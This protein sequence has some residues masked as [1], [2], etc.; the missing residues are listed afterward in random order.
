MKNRL[1]GA[2]RSLSTPSGHPEHDPVLMGHITEDT[3]L[4]EE[5]VRERARGTFRLVLHRYTDLS[6]STIDKFVHRVISAFAKD[7]DVPEDFE[8]EVEEEELLERSVDLLMNRIGRDETLTEFILDFTEQKAADEKSWH[9]EK[10]LIAFATNLLDEASERHIEELREYGISD[11]KSAQK[12]IQQKKKEALAYLKR[13]GEEALEAIEEADLTPDRLAGGAKSGIHKYFTYLRD[14]RI[15]NLYP[16]STVQKAFNKGILAAKKADDRDRAAIDHIT[17]TLSELYQKALTYLDEHLA[18]VQLYDMLDR[19]IPGLALIGEVEKILEE[20]KAENDLLLISDLNKTI[21]RWV[22][23]E[24]APF[25][26]ERIGERYWNFLIDEFQDTSVM[27]WQN[28]L[29]LIE[30]ALSGGHRTMLVGDGKQ[31]IY[32]WRNGDVE[33]FRKLPAIHRGEEE[34]LIREKEPVLRQHYHVETLEVNRRSRKGIVEANNRFFEQLAQHLPD[35]YRETLYQDTRQKTNEKEEKGYVKIR[36]LEDTEDYATQMLTETEKVV[37]EALREGYHNGDIAILTRTNEKG[38]ELARHLTEAGIDVISSE[39][40]LLKQHPVVQFLISIFRYLRHF[41]NETA[42]LNAIAFL[43]S[44]AGRKAGHQDLAHYSSGQKQTYIDLKEYLRDQGYDQNLERLLYEPLYEAT[45]SLIQ[46]FKLNQPA[47]AFLQFFLDHV[48]GFSTKRDNEIEAFLDDWDQRSDNLSIK[49]PEGVNAVRVMT[50]H[51]AKGLEFPVVI[52]PF[53]D[54]NVRFG[55]RYIWVNTK[56]YTEGL[57]TA[58]LPVQKQLAQTPF[59][60]QYEEEQALSRIDNFNLLYVAMTRAEERL[61]VLTKARDL[62]NGNSIAEYIYNIATAESAWDEATQTLTLGYP[63]SSATERPEPLEQQP[64]VDQLP[65]HPWRGRQVI[66]QQ[67]PESWSVE[68]PEGKRAHGEKIHS[69]LARIDNRD[70]VGQAIEEARSEGLIEADETPSLQDRLERLLQG[71]PTREWFDPSL[72]IYRE[73]EIIA[74]N[75]GIYRPDRVV[76]GLQ[77]TI[78]IDF[79]TGSETASDHDQVKRYIK[80][81]K[82]AGHE[83]VKGF[84]LYVGEERAVEVNPPG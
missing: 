58:I 64:L 39:S 81:L 79:K 9:I 74:P 83:F 32:R 68:D 7:I 3:G 6:V 43:E 19:N 59:H 16:S 41:D 52:L 34:P 25:I 14:Q 40:L 36:S 84:L 55:Q 47:T 46:T 5:T 13:I 73:R 82:E 71:S 23:K 37:R 72:E 8:V 12:S 69:I 66:S 17:P 29:P 26:Y 80:L 51:S 2:L 70:E 67:A 61:F 76:R 33:Q 24:P 78:V 42:K 38:T 22:R 35:P 60:Q 77:G 31:A 27:Q 44:R 11:F 53:A 75:G 63:D 57:K 49:V 50:I 18:N 4:E 54:W 56:A 62:K 15:E 30:N 65:S 20:L 45:E 28:F 10:E 48:H 21:A 1:I